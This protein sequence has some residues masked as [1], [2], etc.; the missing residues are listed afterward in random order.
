M[1]EYHAEQI[2]IVILIGCHDTS[3]QLVWHC[4]CHQ[5]HS[6]CEHLRAYLCLWRCDFAHALETAEL[7]AQAEIGANKKADL[8]EISEGIAIDES[9]D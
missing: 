8:A 5:D 9:S 6:P 4:K 1:D 2:Y 7:E 3:H